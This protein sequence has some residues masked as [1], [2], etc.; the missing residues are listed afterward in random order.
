IL[1][2][3]K[4]LVVSVHRARRCIDEALDTCGPSRIDNL[5]EAVDIGGVRPQRLLYRTRYRSERSLMQYDV[6]TFTASGAQDRLMADVSIADIPLD[7][8]EPFPRHIA[9]QLANLLEVAA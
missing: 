9:H 6:H 7:E 8:A 3:R 4:G 5:H 1:D 2:L